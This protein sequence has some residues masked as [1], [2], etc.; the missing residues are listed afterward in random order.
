ME[1]MK[2]IRLLIL[3]LLLVPIIMEGQ[4]KKTLTEQEKRVIINKGTEAPFVGEYYKHK[5]IGTYHCKQCNAPLYSSSDKFES[6]CGWPSFDSEIPG[7]IT[8]YRD[9]DGLRTEIVCSNCDG[10]LGH[11]FIGE[12]LTSKNTRH[13]VNSISMVFVPQK[14]ETAIFAGGCFWGVEH[15]LQKKWGVL[16][17]VSGYTGGNVKNPTYQDVCTGRTG[18]AEAVEVVFD[19]NQISYR[20]LAKLFLEIHD[21]TQMNRQGPDIGSQYRSEIFYLNEAQKKEAQ[22]LLHILGHRGYRIATRVTKASQFYKAEKQ[23]QDYYNTK[24]S[25]PYC[26]SYEKRF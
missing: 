13:C 26:H 17:A 5:E 9:A 22:E 3:T 24:G 6:D 21:P 25:Q 19:S 10:H 12:K 14:K 16:S 18:H 2:I 15:L 7:A 20:E 11:V 8:R 4:G 23:H 1:Y